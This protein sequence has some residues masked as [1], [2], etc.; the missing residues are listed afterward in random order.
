VGAV[1][2]EAVRA[3]KLPS[4]YLQNPASSGVKG[5]VY[6]STVL[7]ISSNKKGISRLVE[8]C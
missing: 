1:S 5:A 2:S 8:V 6:D 4:G 7:M 3:P